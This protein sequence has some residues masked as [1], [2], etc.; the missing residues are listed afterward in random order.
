MRWIL[1]LNWSLDE[2]DPVDLGVNSP[3]LR[4]HV[5]IILANG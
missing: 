4:N 5:S 2:D 1:S 3:Y